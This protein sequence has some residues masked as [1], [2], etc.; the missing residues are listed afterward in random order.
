MTNVPM[1]FIYK[2]KLF[3]CYRISP[4]SPWPWEES[5]S[6]WLKFLAKSIA[7][8]LFNNLVVIPT[9]YTFVF[10]SKGE[11]I[12]YRVDPDSIPNSFFGEILPQIYFCMLLEDTYYYFGHRLLHTKYLYPWA[13]KMHHQYVQNVGIAAEYIHPLDFVFLSLASISL[14]PVLLGQRMHFVTFLLYATIRT[15][16]GFDA[17][18]GYEFP[19]SPVRLLPL[20][21]P[22]TFHDFHH[23]GN[24]GNYAAW[25]CHW[26]YIFGT[27]DYFY[28]NL[29]PSTKAKAKTS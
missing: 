11:Q 6:D 2:Y 1:F 5:Y 28:K 25:F 16:E 23:S 27:S 24:I 10:Y 12:P 21:N 4:H 8:V 9:A 29:F 15:C 18:C 7:L 19:W 3:E 13:H 26:D 20:T 14:G 17:H 22:S